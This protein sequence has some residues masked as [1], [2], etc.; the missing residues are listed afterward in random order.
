MR[1]LFFG[2]TLSVSCLCVA[3]FGQ[4]DKVARGK[5]LVEE[6]AKCQDCHTPRTMEGVLVKSA[7]MKGATL[8]YTPV[9]QTPGWHAK[10]PDVTSTSS[11]FTRW[12]DDG[13]VKFF[14]TGKNPRGNAA[15]A[16][17][18]AYTMTHDDAVAVVAFLKSLK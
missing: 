8:G 18:P 13:L 15:D 1:K 3:I 14:E 4:D 7:W 10:T 17:M 9:V 16:P 6:V 11:L 12:G 2:V 5:Y